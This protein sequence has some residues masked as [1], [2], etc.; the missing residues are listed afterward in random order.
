MS[1]LSGPLL[2]F[3][4]KRPQGPFK[5]EFA[6]DSNSANDCFHTSRLP[7]PCSPGAICMEL[8]TPDGWS[9][10]YRM[11]SV[12]LQTMA[13]M[14]KGARW[15]VPR[16]RQLLKQICPRLTNFLFRSTCRKGASCDQRAKAVLGGGGA[17]LVRLSCQGTRQ[18]RMAGPAHGRGVVRAG[19]RLFRLTGLGLA[20]ALLLAPHTC[21]SF[22]NRTCPKQ[23]RKR[24]LSSPLILV[25]HAVHRHQSQYNNVGKVYICCSGLCR[26]TDEIDRPSRGTS[27][28]R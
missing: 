15:G 5:R 16:C 25:E 3:L 27:T 9:Q 22:E 18:T 24:I 14:I 7:P 21:F 2:L 23:V 17:A 28:T 4:L 10:A 13:T 12:I 19:P 20:G 8:L 26:A 1:C 11:E 6:A